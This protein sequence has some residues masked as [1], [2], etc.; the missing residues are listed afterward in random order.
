MSVAHPRTPLE[1]VIDALAARGKKPRGNDGGWAALCPAHEDRS[2]S[3][4]VGNGTNGDAVIHCHAGCSIDDILPALGLTKSDLFAGPPPEQRTVTARYSYTDEVGNVLFHVERIE[5]GYDGKSKSFAQRPADGRRGPGSMQGVRRVLYN[6][7]A[8]VQAVKDGQTVFIVEGEKDADRLNALGHVATTNPGGAGK[9]AH[10]PD[11]NVLLADANIVVVTDRDTPGRR[12][13][14]EVA[15]TVNWL[16]ANVIVA[17]PATGKDITDHLDA[18]HTIDDLIVLWNSEDHQDEQYEPGDDDPVED[19]PVDLEIHVDPELDDFLN[20]EEPDY[21]WIVEGLLERNDRVIVTASE[22]GGK[23]TLLR[24]IAVQLASGIHPFTCDPIDPLQV[25]YIDC[26]NS[27]RQVR[28]KMRDLRAAAGNDYQKGHLRLRV[29][30]HA[31][32][33]A[34]PVVEADIAARI[35]VQQVDV[36]IIGPLYKLIFDDPIKEMPAKAVADAIDR[37]RLIRGS[38]IIIEAHSPYAEGNGKKRPTRPY[39]ASLWSRW[40]EFGIHLSETGAVT[41]WR[42][43][44]EERAWPTALEHS[45]PW[46]W[47]PTTAPEDE[48]GEWNGPTECAAGIVA[49]LSELNEEMS[50]RKIGDEL[51]ARG[52]SYR[53]DTIRTA[54]RMARNDG[55]LTYRSGPRNSDLYRFN[56][57][58]GS[59]DDTP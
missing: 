37:L 20:T 22:G 2:P 58:Q 3:L 30:G 10:V 1:T 51:R 6:L 47:A 19:D 15:N 27:A 52:H 8:V 23:S 57:G 35:N 46:P 45:L 28:R 39:G 38:A 7:P 34:D 16:A 49:L 14:A 24:Q 32:D 25:L 11:T 56:N 41:H 53:D 42:G 55:R 26:E 54:A 44:R 4:S 29:L 17:E 5:P 50:V 9:W 59:L 40:P 43:Q 31:I 18:G 13:A 12:H 48:P 33:L 36:V 21:D